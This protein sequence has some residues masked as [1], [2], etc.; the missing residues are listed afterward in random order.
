MTVSAVTNSTTPIVGA[1][2]DANP[3]ELSSLD[4]MNLLVTELQNQNPLEPMDTTQ[5]ANQ[6]SQMTMTEQLTEMNSTLNENL[7]MSQSINNTSM[8]A[9]VGHEVTVSGDEV[10]LAGGQASGSML[11][12]TGPGTAEIRILDADGSV[13]T[14][15]HETVDVGLNNIQ[16]DGLLPDGE[17]VAADGQYSMEVTVTDADGESVDSSVLMTGAVG[18]LRYENGVAIVNVFGEEFYVSEIYQIS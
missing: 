16:W 8:L 7:L 5:M 17:T 11:N 12:S 6:L 1:A 2:A 18:G 4:F 10:H 3:N 14:I 15:Y 9:L 13:V